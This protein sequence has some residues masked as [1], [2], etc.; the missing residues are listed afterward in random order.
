MRAASAALALGALALLA[1]APASAT[2]SE[3]VGGTTSD[4]Q[5]TDSCR[6]IIVRADYD[7]ALLGVDTWLNV[8]FRGQLSWHVYEAEAA[9]GPYQRLP[10]ATATRQSNGAFLGPLI[11]EASPPIHAQLQAA[12][13]YAIYTCWD[14]WSGRFRWDVASSEDPLSF[15]AVV[16]GLA[17]NDIDPGDTLDT[18]V[19]VSGNHYR[20]R[21][22]TSPVDAWDHEPLFVEPNGPRSSGTIQGWAQ[23]WEVYEPRVLVSFS[24]RM[25]LDGS[26]SD[27]QWFVG[28]CPGDESNCDMGDYFEIV[29]TGFY[30]QL[31]TDPNDDDTWLGADDLNIPL[32]PGYLYAVGLA[33]HDRDL[34]HYEWR[35][36]DEP[37]VD[38]PWGR[39]GPAAREQTAPLDPAELMELRDQFLSPQHLVTIPQVSDEAPPST[40]ESLIDGE[41]LLQRFEVQRTTRLRQFAFSV[42][43]SSDAQASFAVY[44]AAAPEG[45]YT[46]L[47]ERTVP[48]WDAES[49]GG[50]PG[51]L[52]SGSVELDLQPSEGPWYG[53]TLDVTGIDVDVS[54]SGLMSA[55]TTFGSWGGGARVQ[56][57]S[58]LG[59]V[60]DPVTADLSDWASRLWTCEECV[61]LDGDGWGAAQDCDDLDPAV[62]PGAAELC[63]GL[64]NDCN[65]VADDGLDVDADGFS[66]CV[67]D[68][69]DADPDV[70]PGA[71]ES[72]DGVDT[73]CDGA[74]DEDWDLD[75]DGV[76][77]F[78]TACFVTGDFDCDDTDP[79]VF[80]GATEACDGRDEDCD[81]DIDEDFDADADGAYTDMDLGCALTWGSAVDCDDTDPTVHPDAVELCDGRD[82]NCDAVI[83][84]GF[85]FDA[86]GFQDATAC[87][88]GGDCD[89]D[90]AEI[91]P[92]ASELCDGVDQDCDGAVPAAELDSDAD[93]QR[94]CEG[95]CDDAN[96]VIYS[97]AS[98][99]CDGWDNACAGSLEV[100]EADFDGDGWLACAPLEPDAADGVLGG[101]D[102]GD[103]APSI[104]P[105]AVELCDG[106]DSDCGPGE[107]P[108][109]EADDDGDG[110]LP[111]DDFVP[112]ALG[113]LGGGDCDA[114]DADV[115]PG[116]VEDC[117]GVDDDCDGL[118][119]EDFDTDGDGFGADASCGEVDCDDTAADVFPGATETCDQRDEDC[120]VDV[121]EDFDVDGDHAYVGCGGLYGD[122]DCDDTDDTIHPTAA[123]LCDLVDQDC[124]GV[125]DE[126]FD[127]DGDGA[128]LGCGGL[129]GDE[130]CDDTRA[131][132][133]PGAV[134]LCD[135]RDGD[136]D[137][138][139]AP[140]ELDADGDGWTV[141]DSPEPDHAAAPEGGGDCD[142]ANDLV[143]PAAAEACDGIDQD[144][145]GAADEDFDL[146]GDG[147]YDAADSG[148]SLFWGASADC[149]DVAAAVFPGAVETC[150]GVDADCDGE[151]DEG[152]DA[153]GDGAMDGARGCGATYTDVDCDDAD[154]DRFPGNIEVC[155]NGIDDNCD[156]TVDEDVDE[157]G[158]G[159]STCQ[160][161]D[162]A[163]PGVYLGAAELCDGIDQDCD[164]EVDEDFDADGDG[165][166]DDLP[167]CAAA[168]GDQVDCDDADATRNPGAAERCDGVDQD[169]DGEIDEDFDVDG[170]G[171]YDRFVADCLTTWGGASTD[172]DDL[173]PAVVPGATELCNGVDDD[174]DGIED[175]GF[176]LDG[177][178]Y[179]ADG[180]GCEGSHAG[181]F[182]C[183]DLDAAVFPGAG[184]ICDD[185]VDNDCD[186][187][188]DGE[189]T[190]M[191][192]GGDGDGDDDSGDDD[193]GDD[194]SGDD[195]SGDDDSG[196]DDSGD[197]DSGDDDDDDDSGDDDDDDSGDDDDDDSGDDDDDSGGDD[198]SAGPLIFDSEWDGAAPEVLAGCA[199]CR[200]SVV[201]GGVGG[202]WLAGA[203]LLR[204]RR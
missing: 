72:C 77:G 190:V 138:V 148:C 83:D 181:P 84:E 76:V 8:P 142:D 165:F 159:Y 24:Q 156:G 14:G 201:D 130:D 56:A 195:D 65:G 27:A 184:E 29:D 193:S 106:L 7:Q 157:D 113:A 39:A 169:C 41:A 182:D 42:R 125:V 108:G 137:G 66:A 47:W 202:W 75:G 178:G 15:G 117:D 131:S 199:S 136:C 28:R 97:G 78:D 154:P 166:V 122:E 62:N 13:F 105:G 124:D 115:Y 74:L 91:H 147:H 96:A 102:C 173:D 30:D 79:G 177:D 135:G 57:S 93:S 64:D 179:W 111:C 43:S 144:C 17:F 104:F 6:G 170:D 200:S 22:H 71:S 80:P 87:P 31:T 54:S 162:D 150:D 11:W 168:W 183:D 158:D 81:G 132:I 46:R 95:D 61:D 82:Q 114:A 194:D 163:D 92:G 172:C 85:D 18:P 167:E 146:D 36:S 103:T 161:C 121:D 197:D 204:R 16:G 112:G 44:S 191:C 120:D 33:S 164:F 151:V 145:D 160:D 60:I 59:A 12:H 88:G 20:M 53:L 73:D 52:E 86:D 40:L 37:P 189:D 1:A 94:P 100:G 187:L 186:G 176:D 90:D 67:D 134:E 175:D 99:L 188:T 109:G 203:L 153:D 10:A 4:G 68:C 34:K 32:E 116:A 98:E 50:D 140:D 58:G 180:V 149:D 69:D 141:C 126:G 70:Y 152:F 89:D 119:D 5:S 26:V 101:G 129:H 38:P 55:D 2:V 127:A 63:D 198:D 25:Y 45:P 35:R 155:G 51:W 128:Y 107:A 21:L 118:V 174:C 185:G 3:L 192:P 48:L 133:A 9:A 23:T 19:A 49:S 123:E 139:V 110:Y 196:D 143:S 171:A